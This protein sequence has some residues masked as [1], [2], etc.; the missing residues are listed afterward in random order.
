MLKNGRAVFAI[1]FVGVRVM[2][3]LTSTAGDVLQSKPVTAA[4]DSMMRHVDRVLSATEAECRR[5]GL[6]Q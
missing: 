6:L 4:L 2:R 5:L 3:D 1:G